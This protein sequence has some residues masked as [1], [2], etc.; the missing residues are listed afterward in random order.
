MND[1]DYAVRKMLYNESQCPHQ[2]YFMAENVERRKKLKEEAGDDTM[3]LEIFKP[4]QVDESGDS[5]TKQKQEDG[6]KSNL[7]FTLYPINSPNGIVISLDTNS[8]RELLENKILPFPYKVAKALDPN[9]YRNIE[10]DTW[11]EIKRGKS[12]PRYTFRK[13][14]LF[15]DCICIMACFL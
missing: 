8:A 9:V 12:N 4:E 1:V 5:L 15:I 11:F 3:A 10:L 14:S 7:T 6:K 13:P 2:D